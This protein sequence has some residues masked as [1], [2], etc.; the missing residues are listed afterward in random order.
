MKGF[1]SFS[2]RMQFVVEMKTMRGREL[3][4]LYSDGFFTLSFAL[5]IAT[6]ELFNLKRFA[7]IYIYFL[8]YII[9]RKKIEYGRFESRP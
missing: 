3:L 8:M 1:L 7:G 2:L 9:V 6:L 5:G 4:R